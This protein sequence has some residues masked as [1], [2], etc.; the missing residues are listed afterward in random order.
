MAKKILIV[1]D[2]QDVRTLL[3]RF[4][5]ALGYEI[6]QASSGAEAVQ[7][8]LSEKFDIIIMDLVLPGMTGIDTT[9]ELK[10]HSTTAH[11][12]IV[13]YS[14]MSLSRVKERALQAG[15]AA[16]LLKPVSLQIIQEVIEKYILP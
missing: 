10:R 13:G 3:V 6:V 1:D 2:Y 7:K 8:A 4:L 5:A 14:G 15:M 11:V 12:P 16:F 9:R